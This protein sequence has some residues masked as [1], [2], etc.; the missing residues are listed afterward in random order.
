MSGG[1]NNDSDIFRG[2][3]YVNFSSKHCHKSAPQSNNCCFQE[4]VGYS[5]THTR[6]HTHTV[7]ASFTN[8]VIKEGCKG[9]MKAHGGTEASVLAGRHVCSDV[10]STP[11]SRRG[12]KPKARVQATG[13]GTVCDGLSCVIGFLKAADGWQI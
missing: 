12:P 9:G 11:P 3:K 6:V 13:L 7:M 1:Q 4:F 10:R 8:S 5:V 2:L